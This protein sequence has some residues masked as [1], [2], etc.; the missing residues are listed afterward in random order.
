M[1]TVMDAIIHAMIDFRKEI[2]DNLQLSLE[3]HTEQLEEIK[4]HMN[5]KMK[6]LRDEMNRKLDQKQN[7]PSFPIQ[8]LKN[9]TNASLDKLRDLTKEIQ[10]ETKRLSSESF[11]QINRIGQTVDVMYSMSLFGGGWKVFLHR[12]DGSVNFYQNLT[13]YKTGF[14]NIYGEHWLGLEKLH[15]MTKS[16]SHELL[17]V[18]EDFEGSSKYALYDEFK[19]GTNEEKFKLIVGNYSGTA[20]DSLA[21]LNGSHF[22]TFDQDSE[23]YE[24]FNYA[25]SLNGAWWFKDNLY[26]H[27]N[28]V[29]H[30]NGSHTDFGVFWE[31]FRGVS[32]SLKSATMMFR[33]HASKNEV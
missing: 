15:L 23:V 33:T 8:G 7:S 24:N 18:V 32:Y 12:I 3:Y 9:Q 22:S 25:E 20:G 30:K 13:M 4:H 31:T 16:G 11:L 2:L 21:Y 27:L 19:T 28:G 5:Y 14:G 6:E 1:P 17:V 26:S 10:K 29:Y